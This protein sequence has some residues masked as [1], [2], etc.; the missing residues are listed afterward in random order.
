MRELTNLMNDFNYLSIIVN[1]NGVICMFI[2]FLGKVNLFKH[3]L[4]ILPRFTLAVH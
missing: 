3:M 2:T 4:L 1:R